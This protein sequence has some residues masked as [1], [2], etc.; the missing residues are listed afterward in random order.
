MRRRAVIVFATLITLTALPFGAAEEALT[1]SPALQAAVQLRLEG[2]YEEAKR[3]FT[4]WLEKHAD[5]GQAHFDYAYSLLLEATAETAPTRAAR[6]RAEAYVHGLQAQKLACADPLL[7]LLLAGTDATGAD[8]TD[9]RKFS[10]IPAAADLIKRGEQAYAARK[11]DEAFQLYQEALAL[12]H[13]AYAAALFSGDVLFSQEKYGKSIE[14]FSKAVGIDPNRETAHRYWG[15]ALVKLGRVAEARDRYIDAVIAEPYNR[16][17]REMIARFAT[18]IKT[19]LQRPQIAVPAV[20]VAL[21]D[22]KPSIGYNPDDGPL[23]LAYAL[24][25][26]KW[27]ADERE[28]Y[29]AKDTPS[30]HSLPEECFGLRQLIATAKELEPANPEVGKKLG[31]TLATLQALD[32]AGLLEACILFERADAGIAQ[33]FAAYRLQHRAE[34][35]RYLKSV[36]FRPAASPAAKD[37]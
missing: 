28:K 30:R 18:A 5:D 16:L 4:A 29:F 8:L 1:R 24:G 34:L 27:L 23:V 22:G 21:Q 32:R 17:P 7:P 20:E 13:H 11:W 33:D 15:D 14:W 37:N 25:R 9:P 10:L 31:P 26:V 3:A 36:W 12:D 19:P 2:R 6:L 35:V